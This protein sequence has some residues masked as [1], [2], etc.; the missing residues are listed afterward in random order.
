MFSEVAFRITQKGDDLANYLP[1]LRFVAS[2]Y[3]PAWLTLASLYQESGLPRRLEEAKN[4]IRHYLEHSED[5]DSQPEIWQRLA[6]LCR[7]TGDYAAEIHALMEIC[8]LP[9]IDF[10]TIS[11]TADRI[12][13]LSNR[14]SYFSGDQVVWEYGQ[15]RTIV[16]T[17]VDLME[18]RINEADATDYS[19]LGSLYLHLNS[20]NRAQ[21]CANKGLEIDPD[22]KHC[23]NILSMPFAD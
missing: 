9:N 18:S 7:N 2:E 13:F 22:N 3:P 16:Q 10:R 21:Y 1:M 17:L 11:S 15:Q 14:A 8:R 19:R 23:K 12:N 6:E 4:A 5:T 20:P